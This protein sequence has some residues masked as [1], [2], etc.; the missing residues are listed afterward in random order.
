LIGDDH[1][2]W[3]EATTPEQIIRG[4]RCN[5]RWLVSESRIR[6]GAVGAVG[7][8]DSSVVEVLASKPGITPALAL[9]RSIP[10]WGASK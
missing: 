4:R 10:D 6:I 8:I 9:S 1:V 2:H 3:P 7:N 5:P